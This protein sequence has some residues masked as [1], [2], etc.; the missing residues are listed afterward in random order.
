M[1]AGASVTPAAAPIAA[2]SVRVVVD[3]DRAGGGLLA[4]TTDAGRDHQPA[5][6]RGALHDP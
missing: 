2:V 6:E 4:E 1:V 3:E 5:V